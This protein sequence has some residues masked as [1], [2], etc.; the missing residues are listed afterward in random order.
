MKIIRK[1]RDIHHGDRYFYFL[2]KGLASGLPLLLFL[3]AAFLLKASWPTINEFG[4]AFLF[5]Q[6][7][8]PVGEHFGVLAFAFGTI[9]SSLIAIAIGAPLSIFTALFLTEL[10]SSRVAKVAGFLVEMLAAIPSVVYGLWGIFVLAPILRIHVEP[11]LGKTLGF[12]PLF[13]GPPY[14]VGMLAAGIV[15]A[16]MIIPTITSVSREVFRSVPQSYREAAMALGATRWEVMRIAV[17]KTGSTGI[18]GA[19][20]LGLGR[21]LGETMAV[22]MV[23]GNRADISASLFSPA[24]TMSSVIANEYAEATSATHVAALLEIGLVLFLLTFIVNSLA[25]VFVWRASLGRSAR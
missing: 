12:L 21:A 17:L 23:I 16:I 20:I 22:T 3:I 7:W 10:A 1:R 24:Q 4:A 13:Q 15:L 14:G 2:L 9:V 5:T 19:V 18:L 11:F 25:R 8:D 6:D